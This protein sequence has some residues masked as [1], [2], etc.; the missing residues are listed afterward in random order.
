MAVSIPSR[1][2]RHM[3]DV[4]P[5]PVEADLAVLAANLGL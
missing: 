5:V 3:V 4:A 1:V 2:L